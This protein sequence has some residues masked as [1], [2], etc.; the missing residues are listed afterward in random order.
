[1][2]NELSGFFKDYMGTGL[3]LIWFLLS[4]IY[5]FL[6]EKKKNIRIVFLYVPVILLI[7]FLNPV[8]A[9]RIYSFM[10]LEG[11]YRILWLLPVTIV[12]AYTVVQI[13]GSLKD[14]KK[15]MF[16][17]AAAVVIMFS[18]NLIYTSPLF[19]R[20]EN[21][22]HIP[23]SVVEICDAIEVDG[24]E[25]RA[26]FPAEMIQYVRQY[27]AVIFMPYGRDL[28]VESWGNQDDLYD[29]MESDVI[30]AKTLCEMCHARE[31]HYII[32]A[33]DK[34]IRGSLQDHEYE[35]FASVENYIIYKDATVSF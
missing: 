27:S 22:Y 16:L 6:H 7:V 13:Y 31:C 3:I 24:R 4:L 1:M 21:I 34:K 2:W 15:N 30:D 9:G 5:L 33:E 25:V 23:E 11:Y 20:A 17:V 12:I 19:D 32:L 26:V 8:L 14:S 35:F 18:G 28:L 29:V 10:G